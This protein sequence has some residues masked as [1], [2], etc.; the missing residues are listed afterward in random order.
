MKERQG[1]KCG[2]GR[3]QLKIT[4]YSRGSKYRASTASRGKNRKSTTSRLK[5]V[6]APLPTHAPRK[7]QPKHNA[8]DP[9]TGWVKKVSC[10]FWANM[11]IKL[12]IQEEREQI[13]T[14]TKKMMHCLIFSR[15]IFCHNKR[16]MFKYSMTV[17]ITQRSTKPLRKHDVISV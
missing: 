15:E 17:F 1:E 10:W 7:G 11:S 12:R 13:R 5:N 2:I 9:S 16:F 3:H 8:T 4:S 6:S 14:A